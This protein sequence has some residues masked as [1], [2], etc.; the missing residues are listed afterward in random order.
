M[1]LFCPVGCG[2]D[3][4]TFELPC[5]DGGGD[6]CLFAAPVVMPGAVFGAGLFGAGWVAAD[7]VGGG[8]L[9]WSFVL[10]ELLKP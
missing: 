2:A 4:S 7:L 6:A 8:L 10:F 1:S 3:W 5:D 9:A